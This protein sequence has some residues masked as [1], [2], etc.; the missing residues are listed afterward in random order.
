V[1]ADFLD[2]SDLKSRINPAYAD[3]PGT[4]SF[5]RRRC[6]EEIERLRAECAELLIALVA[7]TNEPQ[8]HGIYRQPYQ[9]AIALIWK[10]YDESDSPEAWAARKAT[11]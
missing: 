6:V 7:L 11:T 9:T 4:E 3:T 8:P 10:H 2:L 5:E 1:K